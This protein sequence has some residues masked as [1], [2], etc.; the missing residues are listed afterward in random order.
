[1]NSQEAIKFFKAGSIGNYTWETS[2]I[3]D[4]AIAV[5]FKNDGIFIG[6]EVYHFEHLKPETEETMRDYISQSV[7]TQLP[8]VQTNRRIYWKVGTSTA[9]VYVSTDEAF[10][11]VIRELEAEGKEYKWEWWS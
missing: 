4:I 2:Q 6:Q 10:G 3:N 11:K 1:M 7:L 9:N 5:D 8:R